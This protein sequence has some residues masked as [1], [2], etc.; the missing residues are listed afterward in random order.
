M[1]YVDQFR[2]ELTRQEKSKNT[3]SNYI[4]SISD[5]AKYI[6]DRT[7]SKFDPKE[8]IELDIREYKSYLLNIAKQNPTSINN[9]LSGLSKFCDYLSAIGVL[10]SNPM[11]QI[12]K[13][14]IQAKDTSPKALSKNDFYK[15]RR[16]F[17]KSGSLRDIAIIESL[18]NTGCRVSELCNIE[19]DDFEI[20]ERKG[21]LTI[22]SGKGSKY[23]T[24][25][26][27]AAVRKAISDYLGVRPLTDD[28][29]L[30]LGQRG[31]LGREAIFRILNKYSKRA[32]VG[33]VNPHMLRHTFC[34]E[35]LTSGVDIV[36][37][38]NL[39]GH[40]NINTTAIYTQ[41]TENE[42]IS[43]LDKL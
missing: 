27:N 6:E 43:A 5:F 1:D 12:K 38:A 17:H 14:K 11:G 37:V 9:K 2:E 32:G 30:F 16:E 22:R 23:R 3:I 4:R 7:G 13:I 10:P 26:L 19:I 28:K 18:Y 41:P 20:S 25:P 24:I 35:L 36:T 42:K 31:A 8:I 34:R 15:L 29:R 33:Q 39:A 40:A 21:T